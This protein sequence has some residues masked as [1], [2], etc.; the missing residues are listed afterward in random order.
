MEQIKRLKINNDLGLHGRAAAR[1]VE[2]AGQYSSRLFFKKEDHEVD[3]SSILSI[4]TLACPKGTEIQAKAVGEDSAELMDRLT[5]LFKQ[6]FGEQ[7]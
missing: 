3:G 5:E 4:L 6:R 2:L 1:I 7:K